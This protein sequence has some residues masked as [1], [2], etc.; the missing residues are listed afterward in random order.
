MKQENFH[1]S[2]MIESTE[3]DDETQIL[4]VTFNNN[5]VYAYYD[6]P[7]SEYEAMIE[8]DSVGKFFVQYIRNDYEWDPI[9]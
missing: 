4:E 8:S 2:R 3:Y 6:V 5:D 9:D 7:L 1:E